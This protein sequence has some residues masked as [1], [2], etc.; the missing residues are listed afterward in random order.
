M[1]NKVHKMSYRGRP[2]HQDLRKVCEQKSLS[3]LR[4]IFK[5]NAT[6]RPLNSRPS[7]SQQR[8]MMEA[9]GSVI[10]CSVLTQL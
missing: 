10:A 7:L 4:P 6:S 5:I 9:A 1:E 3:M 2:K 8:R